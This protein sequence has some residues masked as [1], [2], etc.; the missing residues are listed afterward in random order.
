MNK[1][2]MMQQI[3]GPNLSK[4]SLTN[5]KLKVDN[6]MSMPTIGG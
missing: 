6:L 5:I 1:D 2:D 4:T 3:V